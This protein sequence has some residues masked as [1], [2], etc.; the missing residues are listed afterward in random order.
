VSDH[1]RARET[2]AIVCETA[3]WHDCLIR[4]DPL[5]G[6]R[7]WGTFH[8]VDED[9]RDAFMT[10]RKR[11]PLHAPL[12]NGEALLF[13]RLRARM[14]IQKAAQQFADQRVLV[15]SHGEYI[16]SFWGELAHWTTEKQRAFFHS[17]AGDVRNCQVVE[18]TNT[19]PVTQKDE[20]LLRWVRSSCPQADIYHDWHELEYKKFTPKELLELVKQYPQMDLGHLE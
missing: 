16:E 15:F 2:A 8:E 17:S 6:E 11:D 12:P 4:I 19:H 3:G 18:F 1:I 10:L 14:L 20:G 9:K 13:T 5:I 7:S